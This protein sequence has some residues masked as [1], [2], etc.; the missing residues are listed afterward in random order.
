[1][2]SAAWPTT[3]NSMAWVSG[4]L[5]AVQALGQAPGLENGFK[6]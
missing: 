1:M 5:V 2:L 4:D 3:S 6:D